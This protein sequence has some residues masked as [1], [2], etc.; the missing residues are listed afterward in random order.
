MDSLGDY[1]YLILLVL[2]GLGS[3]LKKKK[4]TAE[5]EP[6]QAKP[7]TN[8]EDVLRELMPQ[9]EPELITETPARTNTNRPE[10]IISYETTE[11]TSKL[12]AKKQVSSTIKTKKQF[13]TEIEDSSDD[14]FMRS[15]QLNSTTDA[16]RAFVY[17]E[18]FNKKY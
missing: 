15:I 11:D 18:I 16:K 6:K 14:E 5:P 8:W 12:R 10:P 3:M 1:I 4:A 9:E 17:S 2:A 7:E 13:F